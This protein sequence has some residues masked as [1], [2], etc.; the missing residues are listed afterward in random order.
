MNQSKNH[1]FHKWLYKNIIVY[2]I[3]QLESDFLNFYDQDIDDYFNK[4]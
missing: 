4:L 3:G 1:L 2:L